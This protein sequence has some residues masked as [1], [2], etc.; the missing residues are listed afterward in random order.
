MLMFSIG[1]EYES[2]LDLMFNL[3]S[4]RL[5]ETRVFYRPDTY[6]FVIRIYFCHFV[7]TF[8]ICFTF[9]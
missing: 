2:R 7:I 1:D 4:F 9:I 8:L 5:P 6:F 3:K